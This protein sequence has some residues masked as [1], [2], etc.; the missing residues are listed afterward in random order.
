M[1]AYPDNEAKE[2]TEDLALEAALA[3]E[4]TFKP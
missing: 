3:P 2:L 4:L 1:T